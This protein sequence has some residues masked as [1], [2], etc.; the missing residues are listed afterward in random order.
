M[1]QSLLNKA[2]TNLFLLFD[3]VGVHVLPKHFYT[4]VADYSWLRRHRDVWESPWDMAGVDWDLDKQFAWLNDVCA[5]HIG[6]VAGLKSYKDLQT[7]GLGY[8]YGPIESQVLHCFI[9][10][11]APRR[12]IEVGSG[13]ST[14]C[15]LEAVRKNER[16]G[17]SGSDIVCIEPYPK[18]QL[19]NVAGVTHIESMVQTVDRAVFETLEAGDLLF[20]DSS[21][22]VKTGSDVSVLFLQVLPKL[23]P[24][25]HV[26]I[27]DINLP[28]LY[29]R[30]A[31][32]TVFGWQETALLAALL[33]G[34]SHLRVSAAMSGL[35]YGRQ[36][37]LRKLL[38]DYQPQSWQTGLDAPDEDPDRHF[39][40]AI[41][42]HVL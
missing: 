17:R 34:N 4:P 28:Y 16:D 3:R 36:A 21:H 18:K 32:D 41:Y 22:S 5:D 35:H 6:E 40:S 13:V 9:R 37:Q 27:H 33:V 11:Y 38:P 30:S 23:R 25:V 8:G 10:K 39:P 2:S 26:H 19:T 20:I 42:L 15:M 7:A 12:I 31:L 29:V 14:A 24:G 1:H